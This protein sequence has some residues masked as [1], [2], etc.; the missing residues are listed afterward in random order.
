MSA[1]ILGRRSVSDAA[2]RGFVLRSQSRRGILRA[3]RFHDA[4]VVCRPSP[5]L[6]NPLAMTIAR[7]FD[8]FL[9]AALACLMGL[10]L[11]RALAQ[12]ARGVRVVVID[13]Q[14]SPGQML[15][16][17][18]LVASLLLWA[19]EIVAHS[20]PLSVHLAPP[21]LRVVLLAGVA[22][23]IVGVVMVVAGLLF[24]GLALRAFGDSWRLGIDR[25]TPGDLVTRDVFSWTRNPIYV[26]LDLLLL[27]TF[28]V[29]G[30]CIF[31]ALA[32]LIVGLL[33]DQIR[34]EERFLRQAHGEAYRRYCARVGRY[35]R[36]R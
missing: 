23:K 17:F 22:V 2:F 35:V 5:G 33:D 16:D 3:H 29:S 13:W 6:R 8:S 27:G 15:R 28:L 31:L 25:Q 21:S 14:R 10:G 1:R 11:V 36:W 30:R 18:L 7:C 9:L 20:W 12:Y 19:F 4:L 26:G 32:L 34:R 24:Y